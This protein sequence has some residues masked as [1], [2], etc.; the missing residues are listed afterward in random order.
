[1]RQTTVRILGVAAAG[2][3]LL[4]TAGGAPAGATGD[5][6]FVAGASAQGFRSTYVVP[7]QFVVEQVW[8]FGGPVAQSQ[9]D[10]SGGAAYGSLPF[11]GESAI[12][13]PG[14][15]ANLA[16][17][18]SPPAYPFYA[19]AQYP[20]TPSSDV[21]DPSGNYALEAKADH[22][23]ATATAI[24]RSGSK[25]ASVASSESHTS[26]TNSADGVVA[27]AE[28][29][30]KGL[31]IAGVLTIGAAAS[32]SESKLVPG[33]PIERSSKLTL[34]GV[35][36][37]GNAVGTGPNGL[38]D[39]AANDTLKA[40]GISVRIAHQ[41]QDGG[42]ATADVLEVTVHHPVPGG[43]GAQGTMVYRFGGATSRIATGT[44][45]ES[46]APIPA[47]GT[48]AGAQPA[49]SSSW[50]TAQAPAAPTAAVLQRVA[51][52]PKEPVVRAAPLLVPSPVGRYSPLMSTPREIS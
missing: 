10:P 17:L 43:G 15:I 52:L 12:V 16:G 31:N 3:A 24:S 44:T 4:A 19:S 47:A 14:L 46:T 11:P 7:G 29:V 40:A 50:P 8:D 32:M 38:D 51:S 5:I 28:S 37:A 26:I 27:R 36:V 42:S 25:D 18:P 48:P 22:V 9:L 21:S 34:T 6:A 2:L 45:P 30:S 13:A 1:M 41:V 39:K 49:S 35:Q 23:S 20:S 33:H